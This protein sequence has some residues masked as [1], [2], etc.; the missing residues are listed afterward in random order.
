MVLGT[1]IY[2]SRNVFMISLFEVGSVRTLSRI[3]DRLGTLLL[4]SL[5]VPV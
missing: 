1:M 5:V 2:E 3:D 4:D